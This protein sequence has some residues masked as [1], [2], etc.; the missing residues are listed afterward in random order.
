MY[1]NKVPTVGE[2]VTGTVFRD[3]FAVVQT[4]VLADHASDER[5]DRLNT[6]K[7]DPFPS[8]PWEQT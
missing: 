2:N 1:L 5:L 3:G 7:G 6:L 4:V 8:F